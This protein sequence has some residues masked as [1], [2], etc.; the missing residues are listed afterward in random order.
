M[1]DVILHTFPPLLASSPFDQHEMYF[2]TYMMSMQG[3]EK[4]REV[5]TGLENGTSNL[6]IPCSFSQ[7]GMVYS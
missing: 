2:E 4:R 7:A 3:K 1:S 6:K 5:S